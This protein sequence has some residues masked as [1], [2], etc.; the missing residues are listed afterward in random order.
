MYGI[1]AQNLAVDV[2]TWD[3]CDCPDH[4]RRINV[5]QVHTLARLLEMLL[6]VTC[7]E[8]AN[9]AQNRVATGICSTT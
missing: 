6:D 8:L 7:Q 5:L 2:I 4:V 3:C 9:V 1:L